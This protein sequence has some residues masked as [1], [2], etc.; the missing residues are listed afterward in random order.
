MLDVYWK[1]WE[2]LVKE[3]EEQ[4]EGD[5]PLLRDETIIEVNKILTELCKDSTQTVKEKK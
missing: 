3:A 1:E 4:L 5:C 2:F